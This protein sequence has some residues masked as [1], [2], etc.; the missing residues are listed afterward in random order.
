[1]LIKFVIYVTCL[2]QISCYFNEW[3]Q[4]CV[5]IFSDMLGMFVYVDHLLDIV[6]MNGVF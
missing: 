3:L 4:A 2:L 6:Q 5:C 1:M